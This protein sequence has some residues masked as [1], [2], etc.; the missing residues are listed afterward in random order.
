MVLSYIRFVDL[1]FSV[2]VVTVNLYI[3][4]YF[5]NMSNFYINS[6]ENQEKINTCRTKLI[7]ILLINLLIIMLVTYRVY[8]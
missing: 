7:V 1:F 5:Y 8:H 4:A 6:L 3:L 2:L